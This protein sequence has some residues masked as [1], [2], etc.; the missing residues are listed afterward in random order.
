MDMPTKRKNAVPSTLRE[1]WNR[2][3][4]ARSFEIITD[5]TPAETA[6]KFGSSG[7]R[8]VNISSVDDVAHLDGFN[9]I[10]GVITNQFCRLLTATTRNPKE[11]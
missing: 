1:Y 6:H 5:L 8:V 9:P 2:A 3:A 7:S 4:F 11:P 10:L